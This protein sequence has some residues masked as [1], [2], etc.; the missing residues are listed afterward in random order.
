MADLIEITRQHESA[1]QIVHDLESSRG[2]QEEPKRSPRGTQ[3][4]PKFG[5]LLGSTWAPLGLLLCSSLG[6]SWVPFGLLLGS[7]WA[8]FWAPLGQWQS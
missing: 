8:P 5:F 6:S 1:M 7:S 2:A 4:E 3:E